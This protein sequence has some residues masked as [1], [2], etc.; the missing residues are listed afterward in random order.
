MLVNTATQPDEGQGV[1]VRIPTLLLPLLLLAVMTAAIGGLS[2]VQENRMLEAQTARLV[3]GAEAAEGH[4]RA[5]QATIARQSAQLREREAELE[6][7]RRHIETIEIQLDGLDAL[8]R[9]TRAALGLAASAGTW[10][11]G[12]GLEPAQ[13]GPVGPQGEEHERLDLIQRRL[14]AG[15][16]EMYRLAAEVRARR[17]AETASA[18]PEPL[19]A[20]PAPPANWPARGDVSSTF[21]WREFRGLPNYHTGVDVILDYGT[22][23]LATGHGLVVGSGW[24]PGYG[25]CVLVDHGGG[26]HTLYA[27]L[28]ATAVEVGDTTAPAD[29]VGYSGSSGNS[30]GPHLHYEIWHNGQPVDPRP[31]MD[32]HGPD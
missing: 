24:Q 31:Y 32:G 14:A 23:V 5:L 3:D 22:A 21:G 16:G 8:S 17:V 25:W 11:D 4:E 2:L 20:A 10:S 9:E 26:Y 19:A 6:M 28:S 7:L 27:H 29:V 12:A 13:G 18:P 15:V 30:T 1:A